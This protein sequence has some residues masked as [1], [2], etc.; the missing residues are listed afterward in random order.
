MVHSKKKKKNHCHFKL[1]FKLLLAT[2]IGYILY[3]LWLY[4]LQTG[5]EILKTLFFSAP[6]GDAQEI[7]SQDFTK[8][9][10]EIIKQ[11]L[12][13][14]PPNHSLPLTYLTL[15]VLLMW[16]HVTW[17][18]PSTADTSSLD[19]RTPVTG[20]HTFTPGTTL[21]SGQGHGTSDS[22]WSFQ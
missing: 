12:Y 4:R 11:F 21:S 7:S 14:P 22:H 13:I 2:T 6:D 17:I 15:H 19:K 9:E 10:K 5:A 20:V 8:T 1:C 3:L 16:P 18:D